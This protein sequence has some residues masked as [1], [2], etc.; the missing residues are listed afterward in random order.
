[1]PTHKVSLVTTEGVFR[2]LAKQNMLFHQCLGELI[3]NSISATNEKHEFQVEIILVPDGNH[4]GFVNLYVADAGSGMTVEM[5]ERA[6]QLGETPTSGNRLNEHGFG[7]KNAL[8]TLSGGN[9]PWKIWT[10]PSLST[11][12]Y[13]VEGPFKQEMIIRDDVPFPSQ[14]FLPSDIS[15][16]IE[17]PVKLSFIQTV[18]GRGAPATDLATL[19]DWFIEHLGVLYRGY[20]QQDNSTFRRSGV[21]IVAIGTNRLQVPPVDVPLG[22]RKIEYFDVELGGN[23]YKLEYQFGTLDE[24]KRDQLVL[25]KKAKFYYQKNQ[26]TQG[27]D[28]RLG[29]RVIATRQFDTIWKTG[30]GKNQL[31]RHNNYNDFVGE[32]LIPDVPRGVLTTVNNKTDFNL[33]DPDWTSIFDKLNNYRPPEKIREKSESELRKKWMQMLKATNRD[34]VVTDEVCVWPTGTAIDVYRKTVS[35]KIILYELKVGSGSPL[36]LYQLKMYWDGL[37]LDK[38]DPPNEAVLLVEDFSAGLEQMANMMN[39]MPP[40]PGTMPYNFRIERLKDKGL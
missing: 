17:V 13:F 34:D 23:V 7:L 5:L 16:L 32:L 8:A 33:D 11:A 2:G 29:K 20:L 38:K 15:V 36:N 35:G 6:L 3:D 26:P 30:D 4:K 21:I 39:S 24:V 31:S 37:I 14:A 40:P 25:G 1:M 22:T 10:K 12:A 28:I 19:R 18:Q 27:I 9:G